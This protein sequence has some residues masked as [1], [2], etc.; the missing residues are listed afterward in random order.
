MYK[1]FDIIGK[2]VLIIDDD[3]VFLQITSLIFEKAG[4]KVITALDGLE[5]ISKLY[6]HNP[7][8]VILDIMLPG[9]DG[10]QVCERIRQFSS[11]PLIMLTSLNTE[12]D[13]LKGLNVGAD[14]FVTK[15][16]SSDVLLAR[17][18]ALL[19]RSEQPN[20]TQIVSSYN[21][22]YLEIDYERHRILVN[23]ELIKLTPIEF[24]LLS[25]LVDQAG[26]T[27]TFEEIL[28][29]VWGPEYQGNDDYVHV[30]ISHLR[31]KIEKDPKNP[32]Y[33]LSLY[34][35]GYLFEKHESANELGSSGS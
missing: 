19:R 18:I 16:V 12:E 35:V 29:N 9:S 13:I 10:Y 2:K 8:L 6:T 11:T 22:G 7:D 33:F 26:R 14:D 24:R 27:L 17:A 30:Y 21:D 32:R 28:L 4:A 3:R 34:G 15:T 5:G 1:S 23:K 20:E 31:N 25:Y